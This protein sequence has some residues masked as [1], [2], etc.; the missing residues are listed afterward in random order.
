MFIFIHVLDLWS[1]SSL[2][3]HKSNSI[4]LHTIDNN[5]LY[6]SSSNNNNNLYDSNVNA[7][8]NR[9]YNNQSNSVYYP[10][11]AKTCH[12]PRLAQS[13]NE[14]KKSSETLTNLPLNTVDT[15]NQQTSSNVS[16]LNYPAYFTTQKL[17]NSATKLS[18]TPYQLELLNSIYMDMKYP[19]SVQ[20]TLIAKCIGITRDQVKV[21]IYQLTLFAN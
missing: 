11:E 10:L 15:N 1:L 12:A 17:T 13:N 5:S 6:H 16:H 8:K 18:Y 7:I 9:N 4:P 19:N 3:S 20:K 2:Q 21:S 14:S